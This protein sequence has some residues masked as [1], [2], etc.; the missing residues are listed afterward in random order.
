MSHV[1]DM[2]SKGL[3]A[4]DEV[5]DN[6]KA[7]AAIAVVRAIVAS[8][9]KG[10]DGKVSAEA[11][12]LE[13]GGFRDALKRNDDRALDELRKRFPAPPVKTLLPGDGE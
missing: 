3:D 11:V 4:I 7:E 10:L 1:L 2:I 12:E 5:T 9:R 6:T 13:I 8:L